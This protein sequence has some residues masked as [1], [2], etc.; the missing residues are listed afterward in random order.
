MSTVIKTR[1]TNKNSVITSPVTGAVSITPSDSTDLTEVSLSLYIGVTGAIKVT[2]MDGSI[3]T[4][5]AITA[6]R[7]PLRVKRVWA[8]G[9]TTTGI[10]AEF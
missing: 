3:V 5:T 1:H 4:Y 10:V 8:T 7:H 2:L 6:G 9:T